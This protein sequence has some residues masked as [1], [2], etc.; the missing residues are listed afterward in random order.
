MKFRAFEIMQ[1]KNI[2]QANKNIEK[3]R[4][5]YRRFIEQYIETHGEQ[6][7]NRMLK[8]KS[9]SYIRDMLKR[10]SVMS[11]YRIANRLAKDGNR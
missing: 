3:S 7:V 1:I 9:T 4:E 2:Q 11:L 5:F 8:K 10:G 6:P